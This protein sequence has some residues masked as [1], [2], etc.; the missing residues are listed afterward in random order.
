MKRIFV[1][2]FICALVFAIA[3]PA[4]G[5]GLFS[6]LH[7]G[8]T[9]PSFRVV[10]DT[11]SLTNSSYD[12][13]V[14]VQGPGIVYMILANADASHDTYLRIT[15]DGVVDSVNYTGAAEELTKYVVPA[16]GAN[17]N[18]LNA[19][20]ADRAFAL[21]DSAAANSAGNLRMDIPFAKHFKLEHA[22]TSGGLQN[23][24]VLYGKFD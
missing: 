5:Q 20:G 24:S 6:F 23:T 4:S 15:I 3:V 22:T 2:T 14:D 8:E 7:G 18:A 10:A 9:V 19:T 16:Y 12:T 13:V 11:T 17:T 21:V 1:L